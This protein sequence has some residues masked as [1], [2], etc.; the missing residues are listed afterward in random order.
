MFYSKC[1]QNVLQIALERVE[2]AVLLYL[3]T[4]ITTIE[5]SSPYDIN[6]IGLNSDNMKKTRRKG[7][8]AE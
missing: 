1:K 2:G 3:P 4:D 6:T 5:K 8:I 7:F